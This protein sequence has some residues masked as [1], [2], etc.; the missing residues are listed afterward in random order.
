MPVIEGL[1]PG[2]PVERVVR[3]LEAWI[4][5]VGAINLEVFGHWRKTVLD[6][7]LLFESA[8]ARAAEAIGLE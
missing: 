5:I 7:G 4:T 3:V 8:I 6:P 2:M 1:L